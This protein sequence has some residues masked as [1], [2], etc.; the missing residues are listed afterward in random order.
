MLITEISSIVEWVKIYKILYNLKNKRM[1]NVGELLV[2]IE[3][4]SVTN[5]YCYSLKY[6]WSRDNI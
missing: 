1:I 5:G 2:A 4:R 3:L 6:V